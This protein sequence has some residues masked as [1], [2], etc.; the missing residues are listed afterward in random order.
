MCWGSSHAYLAVLIWP[1]FLWIT[2]EGWPGAHWLEV[3]R[4]RDDLLSQEVRHL[5]DYIQLCED[6]MELLRGL[7]KVASSSQLTGLPGS[8]ARALQEKMPRMAEIDNDENKLPTSSADDYLISKRIILQDGVVS[9]ILFMPVKGLRAPVDPKTA[10]STDGGTPVPP[11]ASTAVLVAV[12]EDGKASM[13]SPSG[14][15]LHSFWTG[16]VQP[17]TFLAV[18]PSVDEQFV[19]TADSS[20]N[21]RVHNVKV[22]AKKFSEAQKEERQSSLDEKTSLFLGPQLNVSSRLN[23]T[24][25]VFNTSEGELYNPKMTAFIASQKS[26][27][28]FFVV[29]DEKGKITVFTRDGTLRAKLDATAA[30]GGIQ[31]FHTQTNYLIY[32]AGLDW[33]FVDLDRLQVAREYCPMV[34]G[35][36]AAAITDSHLHWRAIVVDEDG[37][38]WV[39]NVKNKSDCRV[40]FM[41]P[42]GVMRHVVGLASTRGFVLGLENHGVG[43]LPMSVIALNVSHIVDWQQGRRRPG[44]PVQPHTYAGAPSLHRPTSHV[45]WRKPLAASRDW[46]VHKRSTEG[47]LLAFLSKDGRSIEIMELLM[48]KYTLPPDETQNMKFPSIIGAMLLVLGYQY[49]KQKSKTGDEGLTSLGAQELSERQQ[50]QQRPAHRNRPGGSLYDDDY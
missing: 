39:L 26:G 10:S 47:D 29:G 7:K 49:W 48:T 4:P 19:A 18:S 46:A 11:A 37:T 13:Y 35:R 14:E 33:G 50:R 36:I 5:Q 28:R 1:S 34:E 8:H 17:V 23:A 40:D 32:T 41:F 9:K 2:S 20:G 16:H 38:P 27:R 42:R 21:I 25:R 22:R 12:T 44:G 6:R 31:S 15:F 3:M 24:M 30:P 45:V 43:T